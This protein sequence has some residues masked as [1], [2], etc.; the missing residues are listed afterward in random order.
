[1][2]GAVERLYCITNSENREFFKNQRP[3]RVGYCIGAEA[4]IANPGT[5]RTQNIF[6]E[7]T[8]RNSFFLPVVFCVLVL[9]TGCSK[10]CPVSG[11]VTYP[12]GTPVTAGTVIFSTPTTQAK[13]TIKPDGSYRLTSINPND[14]VLPGSYSVYLNAAVLTEPTTVVRPDGRG[15]KTTVKV[16]KI[17]TPKF[18]TPN[19]GITCD[20]KKS[21]KFD[22]Q[23]DS[24]E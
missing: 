1:M 12:D 5:G 2:V 22:F 10:Y 7:F 14:G 11:N 18:T 19:S 24:P 6:R 9:L 17:T 3:M 4:P 20:V 15:A 16:T 23:I 21:M 13:G 8:M